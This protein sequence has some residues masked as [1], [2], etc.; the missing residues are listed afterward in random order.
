[1]K[2]N[3]DIVKDLLPLYVDK[4]CSQESEEF[5]H[6]HLKDCP[7]CQNYLNGLQYNI[8][9][10]KSDDENAFKK[11]IKG[12]NFKIIRNSIL[13]TFL[14]TFLL[15]IV[16]GTINNYEFS[17]PYN[18]DMEILFW[19]NDNY[20]W[21]FQFSNSKGGYAYGTHL[22]REENGQPVNLIFI[23]WKATVS[24]R[25]D[26]YSKLSAGPDNLDYANINPNEKMRV[27][28]TTESLDKINKSTEE[29]VNKIINK[30]KLIF[31]NEQKA[32]KITCNLNNQEYDYTLVYY[33]ENKQIIHSLNDDMM[34]KEL[35]QK[36]YSIDGEK[37]SVWFPG[38]K[39]D[40]I[41]K[42]TTDYMQKNGGV[43]N[44][45]DTKVV[46]TTLKK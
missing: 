16:L 22:T 33:K 21:N 23:T 34:P 17:V 11:F 9:T 24:E 8:K 28:Y 43:C 3:C 39:Y 40:T 37:E 38:D 30:S 13:I 15:L 35:L 36:I 1:M 20:K 26:K 29:E 12:I 45:E 44:I 19:N 32:S 42:K 6:K 41:F 27:Y 46:I 31:T 7:E 25:L 14:I 18:D 5:I 4:I 10:R 2:K